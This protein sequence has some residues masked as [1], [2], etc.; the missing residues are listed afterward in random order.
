MGNVILRLPR[1]RHSTNRRAGVGIDHR[2]IAS[3]HS[4]FANVLYSQRD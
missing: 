4:A 3:R 2:D 1:Q